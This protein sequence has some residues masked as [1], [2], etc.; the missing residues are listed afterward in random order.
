MQICLN[1]LE[2]W[3]IK[4][5]KQEKRVIVMVTRVSGLSS[6]MD[7]DSMVTKLMTAE[8]MPLDKIQQ[9]KTY[10]EWQRDDYRTM[11][12]ALAELDKLIFDG[13]GKQSL[14]NKST[15]TVS[16]P[17][18]LSVKSTG[19]NF[20]GSIEVER[21]AT[22]ANM[23]S[24][25]TGTDKIDP[26]KLLSEASFFGSSQ[27]L[28]IQAVNK[29]G[30]L[31]AEKTIDIEATDTLNS[32]IA[33]INEKSDVRAFYDQASGKFSM[34]AKNT[35]NAVAIDS[36]DGSETD[37]AEIKLSSRVKGTTT[38]IDESMNFFTNA[39]KLGADNTAAETENFKRT[40]GTNASV[41]Y[42]G[43]TIERASNTFTLDNAEITVKK[44]TTEPVTFSGVT[45]VDTAVDT[46]KKFVES[47]N[48]L[49]SN[50]KTKIGEQK[51]ASYAPLTDAQKEAMSETEVKMWEEK[52][53]KGTLKNDSSL[54]S[55]LFSMRNS[56]SSSVTGV[57][58][59]SL[60]NIGI[61]T[62]KDYASGGK[63]EI[64]ET[65]LKAALAE[66]PTG[67]YELFMKD[68]DATKGER[69]IARKLRDSLSAAMKDISA[70]AG[71]ASSGN[72]TF[73]LG[74]LLT[75]YDDKISSFE[76]K[77][78]AKETRYYKQFSAMEKA[79]QKANS[80]S[81]SISSYFSQGS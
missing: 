26:T 71:T 78:Q 59:K 80:Q 33:K 75:S 6:G 69:G 42:N 55:L 34:T 3:S 11:N 74:K 20:S 45:D 72:S 8:R 25:L 61:S 46:I 37:V 23:T 52:A 38:P 54:K 2:L 24:T 35:G 10:T 48:A 44:K 47:Y 65:K 53:R 30:S 57:T 19:A 70:N 16:D 63:L 39:L 9:K 13:I 60:S 41:K 62:T 68:G 79:M 17:N 36:F 27:T 67:V 51:N 66:D 29:D 77:L 22:A 15:V 81:S 5:Y 32:L 12:T 1:T 31:G 43:I 49:I 4:K 64:N 40:V 21:V 18:A 56:L 28:V 73:T 58:L 76:E 14:L 50:V 7:I